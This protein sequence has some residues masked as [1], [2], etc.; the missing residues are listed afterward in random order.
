[1]DEIERDMA[2]FFDACVDEGLMLRFTPEETEAVLGMLRR[3]NIRPGDRLLEPG[4][5]AG[6]LTELLA[7]ATGPEGRV[8]ACDLSEGM[9]RHARLRNLPPHV[10]FRHCSVNNLPD[11]EAFFDKIICFQVFPHF[12]RPGE[13]L[14]EFRRMLK[15]GGDLWIAHLDRRA[16]VNARHRDSSGMVNAHR[17]PGRAAMRRLLGNAGFTV[18]EISDSAAG[19]RIH[20]V[21]RSV[22]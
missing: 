13:T 21:N 12:T 2:R 8:V 10:E 22:G 1:M 7:R 5:G 15:P 19:Y 18:V 14:A 4:C 11:G 20:A 17:I 16:A 6:R 9:L 3:W